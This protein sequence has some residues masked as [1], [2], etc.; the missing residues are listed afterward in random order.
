[1]HARFNANATREKKKKKRC[2][3]WV[4]IT[5][6]IIKWWVGVRELEQARRAAEKGK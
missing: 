5:L 6:E 4:A 1:M 2:V 3:V